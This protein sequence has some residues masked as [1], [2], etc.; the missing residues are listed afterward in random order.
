MWVT[1][2]AMFLIAELE[3]VALIMGIDGVAFSGCIVIL[4]GL[5]GYTIKG[6]RKHK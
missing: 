2:I 5:G 4:A 1:I 6:F 3:V